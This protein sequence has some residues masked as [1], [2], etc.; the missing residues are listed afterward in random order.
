MCW[1]RADQPDSNGKSTTDS[2]GKSP[3]LSITLFDLRF[4][5]RQFLIAVLGAALVFAIRLLNSGLANSFQVEIARFTTSFH[6]DRWFVPAGSSGP[7]TSF[8]A[9]STS[10]LRQVRALE[11]VRHAD[12][13]IVV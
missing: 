10:D 5:S 9:M 12:P 13:L 4:R 2:G 1:T 11:G 6:A 8:A 3:M 7:M